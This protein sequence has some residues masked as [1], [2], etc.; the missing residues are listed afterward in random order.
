M[1]VGRKLRWK[2]SRNSRVSHFHSESGR[3]LK[4]VNVVFVRTICFLYGFRCNPAGC[5]V[6][7]HS[8]LPPTALWQTS[9]VTA[10]LFS[11]SPNTLSTL[12]FLI[13]AP[14]RFPFVFITDPLR[15]ATSPIPNPLPDRHLRYP[16]EP[17]CPILLQL[18]RDNYSSATDIFYPLFVSLDHA[19][20]LSF[21]FPF[22]RYRET[23]RN[24]FHRLGILCIQTR[25]ENL[26]SRF[27][28][29]IFRPNFLSNKRYPV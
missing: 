25:E 16:F 8:P 9:L 1:G 12:A 24:I 26:I 29:T 5:R 7:D 2:L 28:R 17:L 14:S 10:G 6:F 4:W 27:T 11:R 22:S 3:K 13:I 23:A 20:Y 21:T 18:P 15:V 19:L